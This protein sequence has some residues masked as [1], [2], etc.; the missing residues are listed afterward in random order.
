MKKLLMAL[1]FLTII[2]IKNIKEISE[3]DIAKSSQAFV[4]VGI[5]QGALLLATDYI[6]GMV[7]PPDLVLA[8]VL[9]VLVLSNGGFHL[10]GLAD[11]FDAIAAKSEGN[12]ESDREKR[13]SIM[14]DSATGPAGVLAM[15][16]V[17]AIK[18]L[19][20][21]E[22]SHFS[23]FN[24]HLSLLFMPVISKWAMIV[25]MLH[26]RP[27]MK[28]GLGNIFIG[29]IGLKEVV[30]STVMIALFLMPL[31]VFFSHYTSSRQYIFYVALL[32]FMYILCHIWVKLFNKRFGGLNGD[33]LGAI[34]E[35]T[36]ACFLL[37]VIIWLRLFI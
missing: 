9:L 11:T 16:F 36:E 29:R 37:M 34:S 22:L 28:E 33:T 27:S 1:Q 23:S 14:K 24:Y 30:V 13:L 10:D 21:Q 6:A 19:S 31:P 12:I 17:L 15:V 3:K 18:Y 7:F 5:I 20:L 2:P 35:I 25:S 26:G 8:M 32:V 4:V